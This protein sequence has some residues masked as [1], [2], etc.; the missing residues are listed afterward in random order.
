MEEKKKQ[1]ENP[2]TFSICGTNNEG[3][4]RIAPCKF[5]VIL[6]RPRK[7]VIICAVVFGEP[8]TGDQITIQSKNG[9]II[10]TI[11]RIEIQH[12]QVF[13]AVKGDQIG[14]CLL[15]TTIKELRKFNG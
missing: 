10:D 1:K 8:V 11:S 4:F 7:V 3:H 9:T 13:K 14:I 2:C 12:K 6:S 15:G 5:F